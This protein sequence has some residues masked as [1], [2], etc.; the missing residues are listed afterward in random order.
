MER[1][2]IVIVNGD[3]RNLSNGL[4]YTDCNTDTPDGQ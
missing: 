4:K 2:L 3:V 1:S